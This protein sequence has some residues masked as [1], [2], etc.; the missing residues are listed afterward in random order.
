MNSYRNF[1]I[2]YFSGKVKVAQV[3]FYYIVLFWYKKNRRRKIMCQASCILCE[4]YQELTGKTVKDFNSADQIWYK[5]CRGECPS[6]ANSFSTKEP[7]MENT[8]EKS[9][10]TENAQNQAAPNE[11]G[12][13]HKVKCA[14]ASKPA[15]M[16]YGALVYIGIGT[17]VNYAKAHNTTS[18]S[19]S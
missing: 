19:A 17:A 1:S 13:M 16:V 2:Q 11:Q 14:L 18:G 3:C 4:C 7:V 5:G 15:M 10:T 9:T 12:F 6:A 8:T